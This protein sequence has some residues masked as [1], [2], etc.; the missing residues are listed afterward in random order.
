MR[1]KAVTLKS[2]LPL[3]AV[4]FAGIA[5]LHA[6]GSGAAD[7]VFSSVPFDRWLAEGEPTHF[8]WTVRVGPAELNNH[9]RLQSR[10]EI[11]LDG[12]ELLARRGHGQLVVMIQFQDSGEKVYQ[13]HGTIDLQDVKDD[14]GKSNIQYL[15][16]AFVL[17]GDY[18][19]GVVIFDAKTRDHWA[20]QKPLHV[21]SLRND[22]LPGVWKDLP[23]V[24]LLRALETPDSWYL[25]YISTPLQLPLAVRRPLRVEI[26]MNASSSGPSRGLSGGTVSNRNMAMLVPEL[27]VFSQMVVTGGSLHITL[28]D[29]PK[30]RVIFEQNAVRALDWTRM[31]D[32][33]TEADPNKIDV[34]SLEHREENAKFFVQQ[35]RERLAPSG[36]RE[37][38][39]DEPFRVLIV[40]AAPMT[41]DGGKPDPLE[42][43]EKPNGRVYYVRCHL[44]LERMPFANPFEAP[45][46]GRRNY[47]G[48]GQQSLS[49]PEA[50]DSLQPLLKPLQPRLFEVYSPEQFR[51]TLGI[52]LDELARL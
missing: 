28:L 17:P 52:L 49:P 34:R 10:V 13:T 22:P 39:A 12:N 30:R 36:G 41:L 37:R 40:L 35:I 48:S 32:A 1:R 47:P 8:R 5:T 11:Q 27:K 14:A 6:Q 23:A 50:F 7:P 24:E 9:Q 4:G 19:V 43:E 44:P 21:N 3:L 51:K 45:S 33:L 42:L 31:R 29:I 16:D 18:R 26:V 20:A 2:L 15:Q 25:P 46:R 38:V